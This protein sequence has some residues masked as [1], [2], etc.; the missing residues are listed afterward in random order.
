MSINDKWVEMHYIDLAGRTHMVGVPYEAL[1]KEVYIDASSVD[2]LDISNSDLLLRPVKGSISEL[3]WD[4]STYRALTTMWSDGGRFWGDS[5]WVAEKTDSYLASK[6][7]RAVLGAEVEFFIHR[8]RYEFN[9]ARQYLNVV[10]DE[11]APYGTYSKKS[12]YQVIDSG[13]ITHRVRVK[14]IQY[15]YLMGVYI[16]KT[17]HEVAPNQSELVTPSGNPVE[18]GD[19]I[20]TVKYV[21]RRVANELG[22]IANFMPK[23]VGGDNG[24]GMHVHASLWINNT[25]LFWDDGEI[26]QL[27]RYFIGGILDHGRSLSAIVAPTVNS[28]KRLVPGYEAPVYLAWGFSNRS[29]AVRVPK[30][31]SP[32]GARIE[33]RVPDPLANPYLA[34]SAIV[35]AGLDGIK[36]KIDPG[37]PLSMNSYKLRD[38]ELKELGIKTLPTNLLEAL[39]ELGSDNSYLKPFFPE[40]LL[41]KYLEVK[42]REVL[43]VNSAPTPAEFAA[44]L[45]W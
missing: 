31:L 3:P 10:N 9:G 35:L 16:R 11:E 14:A 40:E 13:G 19:Y 29:V 20:L 26:S 24:S 23:P 1:D 44:Y 42:R 28:Y 32:E 43:K 15:L 39:E 18:V 45:S 12:A 38:W 7:Y 27:A 5:R 6:N 4:K 33:F 21:V 36:K 25:N 22:Y 17:H 41:S 8:I 34:L 30:T 37:D 2:M